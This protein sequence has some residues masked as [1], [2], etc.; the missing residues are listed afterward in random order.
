MR[1]EP[2]VFYDPPLHMVRGEDVWLIDASGR[3]YLD[4]YNNVPIVGH[5]HSHV[6]EAIARQNR[7]LNTNTR[8]LSEEILR[9]GERLTEGLPGDLR[10]C[11]FVNSGSEANDIAWRMATLWTGAR[12]GLV[13]EF[14]YHGITEAIDGFSPSASRSGA[15]A[16]HMRTLLAPDGYRGK[17]RD[18]ALELG[19]HYAADA[20]IVQ[21]FHL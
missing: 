19:A 16:P 14:G 17:Y 13:Q 9:Y 3:P 1:I 21:F 10:I 7:I 12:G 11:A 4:C 2:Y 6:T 5:C 15:I 18:G 8:Y 20:R